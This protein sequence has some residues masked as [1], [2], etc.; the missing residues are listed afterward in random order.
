[1][2]GTSDVLLHLNELVSTVYLYCQS[3]NSIDGGPHNTHQ[4][5]Q[6]N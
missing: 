3:G 4:N 2:T 5:E 6:Q 1:M